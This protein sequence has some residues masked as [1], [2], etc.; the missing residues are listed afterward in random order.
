MSKYRVELNH[1]AIDA[2]L[3]GAEV[4]DL[5]RTRA[6]RAYDN[7]NVEV[8]VAGTRAVAKVTGDNKNNRLLKGK[9]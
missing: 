5:L 4:Q 2:F 1:S 3:K 7:G 8:F 6:A 9:K